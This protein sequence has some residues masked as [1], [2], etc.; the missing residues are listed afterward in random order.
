MYP[1]KAQKYTVELCKNLGNTPNVLW[2]YFAM[3]TELH[4]ER[5]EKY[6]KGVAVNFPVGIKPVHTMATIKDFKEQALAADLICL[7]GGR[8]Q[9]LIDSLQSFDLSM[10]FEGKVVTGSSAGAA[11]L[12]TSFFS[13]DD[14]VCGDGLGFVPVKF[15]PHYDSDYGYADKRGPIDWVAAKTKLTAYGDANLP[16]YALEEGEYI[17]IEK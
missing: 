11:L 8:T 6:M 12:S 14:R 3:S 4:H 16:V 2:C 7:Q 9:L 15:I 1:D 10:L 5:H 17:V 13:C